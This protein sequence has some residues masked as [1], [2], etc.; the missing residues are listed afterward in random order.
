MKRWSACMRSAA[1]GFVVLCL[2]AVPALG[3]G[4]PAPEHKITQS[5]SYT[6]F[7]P[8]YA[9]IIA[10]DKPIGTLMVAIGLDIPD[11]N[12]R[13]DADHALPVLRDAYIRNLMAYAWSHVRPWV[14]PDV[15]EIAERLQSVTD[16]TLRKRGASVL[17]AQ[18]MVRITK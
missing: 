2:L 14:Q 8:M 7:A 11:A 16:K 6:M 4:T 12:L 10:G 17:L 1:L 3:D 9:T 5:E 13:A 18:V 15:V